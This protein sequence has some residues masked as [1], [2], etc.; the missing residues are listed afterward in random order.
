MK[1][2]LVKYALTEGIKEIDAEAT[3]DP[4]IVK[5]Q[6]VYL[7]GDEWCHT[8]NVAIKLAKEMRLKKIKSLKKQLLRLGNLEFK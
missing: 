5:I 8:R 1:V 2:Y 3:S 4:E 7:H 6:Y